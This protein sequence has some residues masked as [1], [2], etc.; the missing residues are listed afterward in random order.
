MIELVVGVERVGHR[1]EFAWWEILTD[2]VGCIDLGEEDFQ[3]V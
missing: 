3:S 1:I 2:R